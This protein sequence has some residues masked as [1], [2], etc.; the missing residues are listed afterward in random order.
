MSSEEIL[1]RL[2]DL[3]IVLIALRSESAFGMNGLDSLQVIGRE[4]GG[5]RRIGDEERVVSVPSGMLLRLF[6][7]KTGLEGVTIHEYEIGILI[8]FF[9]LE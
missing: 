9:R 7:G 1:L 2:F 8:K 6:E 4:I 5:S 3:P